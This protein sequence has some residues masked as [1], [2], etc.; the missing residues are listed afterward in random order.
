[1]PSTLDVLVGEYPSLG[2]ICGINQCAGENFFCSFG[3]NSYNTNNQKTMIRTG[4]LARLGVRPFHSGSIRLNNLFGELT[5]GDSTGFEGTKAPE[6]QADEKSNKRLILPKDDVDLQEYYR[7]QVREQQVSSD[8]YITPMKR[9]LFNLNVAQNGFFK[10]HQFVTKDNKWYK[11]SLSDKEIDLLEPT[12]YLKSLRIKSSMKKATIV[13]RF[14][15]GCNVKQAINQLHFNPKKMATELEKLLKQGLQQAK[16]LGL[17]ENS[18][19]IQS[20]WTGSDG[21]WQKRLDPK[22]RGRM[23]IIRH[24]YIHLKVVIKSQM[25]K[26]RLEYESGLKQM[27]APPVT[28]LNSE[29]LNFKNVPYYKW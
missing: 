27:R 26:K 16:E 9:E 13:N 2:V 28:G 20:L 5:R 4:M 6:H 24:R 22:S 18:V 1:M 3:D 11:L 23:G 19:Y 10:N 25:T 12:I 29:P 7:N 21:D 14:V 15:R 17:E 8:K